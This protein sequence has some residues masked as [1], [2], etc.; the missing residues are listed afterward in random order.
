TTIELP[1]LQRCTWRS[2]Q[3]AYSLVSSCSVTSGVTAPC[4]SPG[5]PPEPPVVALDVSPPAPVDVAPPPPVAVLPPVVV[6][7]VAVVTVTLELVPFVELALVVAEVAV[8]WLAPACVV[9]GS[10]VAP[11]VPVV[12]GVPVVAL[13][14]ASG[15]QGTLGDF[16]SLLLQATTMLPRS[17]WSRM[18]RRLKLTQP[19]RVR[20]LISRS[21]RA[22]G[23]RQRTQ[24]AANALQT[25]CAA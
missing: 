22:R 23:P 21:G 13:G 25:S 12:S 2:F 17:K 19:L 24:E 9:V 14:Q 7:A 6:E 20:S 11:T 3:V 16:G 15:S 10:P 18:N 4:H 5:A 1:S 8:V